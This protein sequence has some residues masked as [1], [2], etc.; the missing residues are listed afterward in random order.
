MYELAKQS[1]E[2]MK[3]KARSLANPGNYAKDQE[4]SSADWTPAPPLRAEVKTGARPIMKPSAKGIGE[5]NAA[6]DTKA[7]IGRDLGRGAFKRGGAVKRQEGGDVPSAAETEDNKARLGSMKIKPV[8]EAAQHYKKGGPV[9][10][11]GGGSMLE[12]MVGKPKTGSDMSQVGKMG[13]A[14]YSQEEK[15]A[16]NRALEGNDALPSPDEAA[17][18]AART[19]DKHGG[20]IKRKDGGKTKWIQ[21]AIK[22]PGAL[23][24]QLGVPAG[25]KIPAK[26]LAK[27]AEKG[28]KL[29]KRARLAETLKRLGK[30]GGGALEAAGM[31]KPKHRK[32][33]KVTDIKINILAGGQRPQMPAG[34]PGAATPAVQ[35]LPPALAAAAPPPAMPMGGMPG[36]PMPG[37]PAR[38]AGGRVSKVASSYRDMTAGSG[39]GLGREQKTSIAEKH[40]GAPTRATGGKVSKKASSYRDMTAGSGSGFGR[41]QKES[42]AEKKKGAPTK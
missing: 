33:S 14:R 9:K 37:L 22:K 18:S 41:L 5:S 30:A 34:I 31:S 11:A 19:G 27:A 6:R 4:V 2:K 16:L 39:S 20:R 28:G 8:R 21:S 7:A 15:G 1:R 24:K 32:D 10:K 35:N 42:I 38:K 13:T 23:H 17:E 12:R 25:E 29:G 26:K 40:K 36:A 3:A